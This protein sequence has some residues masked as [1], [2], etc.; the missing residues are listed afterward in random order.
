M[1]YK[2]I[3][4][5][6]VLLAFCQTASSA[7]DSQVTGLEIQVYPTGWIPSLQYERQWTAKSSI[8]I[9]LG[10]NIFDHRDLGV[11]PN[12]EGSGWGGSIGYRRYFGTFSDRWHLTLKNDIWWN[13]VEYDLDQ[14]G[15]RGKSSITV[16]QPTL[17]LGHTIQ[18]KRDW[19]ISPSIA[20]GLEWNVRT[21]GRPTGEGP[22]LLLGVAIGKKH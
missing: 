1:R 14:P 16:L 13:D 4:Y 21:S 5:L 22:I 20:F 6:C 19:M 15:Q 12:E 7:Q 3:T 10:T 11:Q 18:T 2:T 9:R 8:L 17:A